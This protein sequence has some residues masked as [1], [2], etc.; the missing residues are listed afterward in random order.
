MHNQSLG[1]SALLVGGLVLRK[2]WDFGLVSWAD[3]PDNACYMRSSFLAPF[4]KEEKNFLMQRS[5]EVVATPRNHIV[6]K[7]PLAS[8][9]LENPGR[10]QAKGR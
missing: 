8:A 5:R 9:L 10:W 6:D 2:Q 7:I 3:N 1:S 4:Q